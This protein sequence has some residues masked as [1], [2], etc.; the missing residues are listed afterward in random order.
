MKIQD[1]IDHLKAMGATFVNMEADVVATLTDI[2]VMI[3]ACQLDENN[4]VIYGRDYTDIVGDDTT[5]RVLLTT[6][7]INDEW[8]SLADTIQFVTICELE[9]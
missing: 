6:V 1:Y 3:T 7:K 5:P 8:V 9:Y 2:E 4:K